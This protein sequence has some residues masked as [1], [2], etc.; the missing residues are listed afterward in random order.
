[1]LC[2]NQ[3]LHILY[4]V[5]TISIGEH[6]VKLA[7]PVEIIFK[8]ARSNERETSSV[9]WMFTSE[10]KKTNMAPGKPVDAE[11]R[12]RVDGIICCNHLTNFTL[13]ERKRVEWDTDIKDHCLLLYLFII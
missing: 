13:L 11:H 4:F 9:Y 7:K 12:E 6:Q 2:N 3:T 5:I 8:Y 10:V 1:M